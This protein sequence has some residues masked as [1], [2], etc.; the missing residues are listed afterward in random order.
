MTIV[1]YYAEKKVKL[2]DSLARVTANMLK[3]LTE[4]NRLVTEPPTV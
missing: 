1:D 2:D 3:W 4:N